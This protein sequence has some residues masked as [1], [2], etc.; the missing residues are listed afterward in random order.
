VDDIDRP[1]LEA[2]FAGRAPAEF[3]VWDDR[4][5]DWAR[6]DL[7]VLRSTWDYSHRL[8]EFNGWLRDVEAASRLLNPRPTLAWNLDKRYLGALAA[9]GVPVARTVYLDTVSEFED[10]L[11]TIEEEQVVVKPTISAG[12]DLTGRF[13]H[14]DPAARDLAERILAHGKQVMLQPY[15]ESVTTQG[16]I[17]VVHLDGEYSHSF[18]KG[19][20]LEVGG[21]LLGGAYTEVVEPVSP[22]EAI[23]A[24]AEQ[25][26]DGYRKAAATDPALAGCEELLYSRVDLIIGADGEPRCLELELVEPSLFFET[27]VTA[28]ARFVDAVLNRL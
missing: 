17:A 16:E 8:A 5:V 21:G 20:L 19:P 14:G 13:R 15:Y 28:A 7:V 11:L 9:G 22:S 1:F 3:V 18:R 23:L 25:V 10:G 4:D 12:S 26:L 27:D 24:T 2:A 6:Y